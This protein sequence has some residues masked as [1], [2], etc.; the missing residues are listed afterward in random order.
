M[1]FKDLL[2][3]DQFV[4][5]SLVGADPVAGE[6][7]LPIY[8]KLNGRFV[9]ETIYGMAL[10]G[11]PVDK[12]ELRLNAVSNY[13]NLIFVADMTDVQRILNPLKFRD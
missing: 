10:D 4:L 11:L 7:D 9:E 12:A 6:T 1:K 2:P 3:G 5:L 8:T 13:G